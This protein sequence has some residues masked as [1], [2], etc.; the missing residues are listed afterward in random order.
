MHSEPQGYLS[1]IL[2]AH[3]PFV[4]HP[5]YE[6]F[7]EEDWLYEAITET[8]IP[9]I[10]M[11]DGLI[12]DGIDFRL[13][14]SMTPPLCAML[15]DPLLQGRYLRELERLIELSHKEIERTKNNAEFHE[16]AW[17]Y[18]NM[19]ENCRYV[20][21]D[22]YG[23]N[24][25]TAFKK[26]QDAGKLEI[27]TCGATH[28]YLPLMMD[29]PEAVRAQIL[30]ARDHYRECF[31]RDPRG[32]W[33]P[34]CAFVPGLDKFLQ[35]AEIRWFTVD[36]HGVLFAEPRPAYGIFAP[37][38]TPSGPAAFGRDVESSKQVWSAEEGY[39]GDVNYREFYRD[40]GF[41]LDYDY[42]RPYIQPN[43]QRKFVGLKYYKI[44]GKT[45]QKQAYRPQVAREIAAS[46]AGN[47]VFNRQQQIEHLRGVMGRPPIVLAP[48]DA[49]LYGH[50]WFEGPQF[51]NFF[52]RKTA[53]DQN[54][55]KTITPSE[56][57]AKYP[58]QQ[59][60]TPSASSWGDKGYWEVWLGP[61]NDWIY[62]HLHRAAERMI[63]IARAN[64]NA[65]GLTDRAL[66]QAARELLLAQSSDW[67]FIMKMGTMVPYAVKRTKDHLLR[68]NRICDEIERN[69]IDE[70]FL[71]NCEWRDNIFPNVNWRYYL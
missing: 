40:V 45:P 31:G 17:F 3:L 32:I 70:A 5:E 52:L 30:V 6:N 28:G 59:I 66:K 16:L 35:E 1:L 27:I 47:F 63:S 20:F 37:I 57:L 48:Y 23:R 49:E 12:D 54:V 19:L 25:I 11:M 64:A 61:T 2:H 33:L 7:L 24:L 65:Y 38:F 14:M 34:E 26:F 10:N 58:T 4:R 39:P 46:H 71:G 42:I 44:T 53:C 51:L 50:W 18:K 43:G 41:D 67:A 62:T 8:Y 36:S 21:A 55:F 68:F 22:K 29:Y 69:Q 9:L 56:Y 60:A 15:L 13:T